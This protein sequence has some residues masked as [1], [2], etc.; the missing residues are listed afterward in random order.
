MK[1]ALVL[2]VVLALSGCGGGAGGDDELPVAVKAFER[3]LEAPRGVLHVVTDEIRFASEPWM[4]DLP[5]GGWSDE[6]WLDLG[7]RGWRAH[8]T[9]RDGGF[10]Q[11]ADARGVRTYTRFGYTGYNAAEAEHPDYLMRP[12]RAGIVVD[13]VRLVRQGR[14]T[15]VGRATV[16]DRP[17]YI[18]V[19]DPAPSL[20]TCLYVARDDGDLLRIIHRGERAGRMRLVI[21]LPGVGGR[22]PAPAQ[23]RR[24]ARPRL[25]CAAPA[26]ANCSWVK[27]RRA[28][29]T[30]GPGECTRNSPNEAVANGRPRSLTGA[31]R[32]SARSL[33]P[34]C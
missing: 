4:P 34:M 11:V 21:G 13:P 2:A 20:N 28:N 5:P 26:N 29:R 16:R 24:A 23:P 9:T 22:R 6:V 14:L 10:L 25:A 8:R 7:G 30:P 33:M 12:W 32:G 1:R 31:A 19:V 27:Q 15:V 3:R 17:A 18:V